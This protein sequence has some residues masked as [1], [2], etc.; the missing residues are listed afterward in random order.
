MGKP[1][2][3][4]AFKFALRVHQPEKNIFLT[5]FYIVGREIRKKQV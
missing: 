4:L 1:V 2:L 5:V 3:A